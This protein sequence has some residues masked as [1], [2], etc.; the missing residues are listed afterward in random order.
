MV[1]FLFCFFLLILLGGGAFHVLTAPRTLAEEDV[2][3]HQPDL[4]NG[5]RMFWA[6]GCA[7][8]HAVPDGEA[9]DLG[10]GQALETPFGTF[11]VPNISPDETHGIGGWSAESFLNAMLRGVSPS[12]Q[13]YYPSFPY[14]SYQRMAKTDVL[15]LFAYISTLP[16]SDNEVR[17]HEMRFPYTIRRGIGLWK[18]RHMDGES[19][20]PDPAQSEAWN[21]G[22]YL[23]EGP[24][25][26]G[27]CHTPRNALGGLRHERAFAGGAAPEGDGRVPNITP[28]PDGIGSWSERDIVYSLETGFTP[29][30]D[31]FG[32]SMV[33]VQRAIARLP[34]EDREAIAVY[35]K[36]L[37]PLPDDEGRTE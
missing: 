31:T 7:S 33:A 23:V 4:A 2:P 18:R 13:H 14:T 17:S 21:R 1:R 22:A 16:A 34:D 30:F 19:F 35:L 10:G 29:D 8:C 24:A 12:G 6:G 36:S 9:I 26:C 27:E 5:E 11:H 32:G 37:E 25:H 15:D 28:H 20:E 3:A